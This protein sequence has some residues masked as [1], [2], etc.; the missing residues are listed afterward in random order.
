MPE[1]GY[2]EEVTV[3]GQMGSVSIEA[4]AD[5]GADRTSID[6]DIAA[7]IGAGPIVETTIT[8]SAKHTRKRV[9]ARIKVRIRNE[10]YEVNA[11]IEDRSNLTYKLLIGKDV[12]E[13]GGFSVIPSD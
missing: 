4:K 11:A 5:T 6:M 9:L 2:T 12:L 10:T 8:R 7:E 3:I 13:T 1:I